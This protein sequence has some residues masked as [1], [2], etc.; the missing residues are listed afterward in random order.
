MWLSKDGNECR[1]N[2]LTTK[3]SKNTY[4]KYGSARHI[5]NENE[6]KFTSGQG[7]QADGQLTMFK[8]IRC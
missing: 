2:I 8:N 7:E 4:G 6:E 3:V 1:T 5:S